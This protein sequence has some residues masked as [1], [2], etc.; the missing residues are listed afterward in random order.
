MMGRRK[1]LYVALLLLLSL[2][3]C[4]GRASRQPEVPQPRSELFGQFVW[5]ENPG[6]ACAMLRPASWTVRGNGAYLAPDA[7]DQASVSLQVD[8]YGVAWA[9]KDANA[10]SAHWELYKANPTLEGWTRGVE[11]MWEREGV[12]FERQA[13]LAQPAPI[14]SPPGPVTWSWH[15]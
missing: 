4:D 5:E 10:T 1:M 15:P 3:A 12:P 9:G 6:K 2:C 11:E 13:S 7:T 8:N 14:A